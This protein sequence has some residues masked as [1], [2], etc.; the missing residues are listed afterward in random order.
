MNAGKLLKEENF[1]FDV[2][3]TSFLKR[4]I[5]TLWHSLEQT[6]H[7][8]IPVKHA[9]Q[10]NERHYGALQGMDKQETVKKFGKD[11]VTIWRRS[12][13]IP[14]PECDDSSPMLPK[15]DPKYANIPAVNS[16]KTESLKV[17]NHTNN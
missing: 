17:I 13:D 9:W 2:A 8:F 14:P 11:Q 10:L 5:K 4:A 6:D 16:I 1:K 12:Y 3:Y 15:N 7:M